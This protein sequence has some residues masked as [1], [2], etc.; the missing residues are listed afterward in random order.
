MIVGQKSRFALEIDILEAYDI[1]SLFALGRFR[2]F[3]AGAEYGSSF[4]DSTYLAPSIDALRRRVSRRGSHVACFDWNIETRSIISAV[5][6]AIYQEEKQPSVFQGV[7]KEDLQKSLY[8]DGV[9]MA[10]DGSSAFDDGSRI[11]HLER[12]CQSRLI[13][14]KMTPTGLADISSCVLDSNSVFGTINDA[15]IEIQ[16]E[17]ARRPKM[18]PNGVSILSA[19]EET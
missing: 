19:K 15:L 16:N 6:G 17:W 10:P 13:G 1:A 5:E 12:A 14:W 18:N 2:I 3:I 4:S 7:S 8:S 11:L 9:M